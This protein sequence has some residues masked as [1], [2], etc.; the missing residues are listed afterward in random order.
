[1]AQPAL[2]N[3]VI[4]AAKAG[5]IAYNRP[6]MSVL[7]RDRRPSSFLRDISLSRWALPLSCVCLLL[8]PGC[9]DPDLD[10]DGV[11][12]AED[13]APASPDIRPGQWEACD[14][15]DNNCD[16]QIDELYDLDLDGFYADDPGC[17]AL[18]LGI[19]CNDLDPTVYPGALEALDG[20]DN[21]C[22]GQIDERPDVDDDGYD[23][24]IDCD[25][26]NPFIHPGALEV[27]DGIDNDC[28]GAIDPMWDQDGDG[29]SQCAEIPDCDDDDPLNGPH[30]PEIC[31]GQDNDCDNRSDEGFDQDGDGFTTCRG[32]CNDNDP[33]V[34]PSVA[35]IC[36]DGVDNDCDPS[37][38]EVED[39]DGDGITYCAG[40]CND[41]NPL[42]YPGALEYCDGIDN[43]C[44]GIADEP[45]GCWD[46]TSAGTQD[47]LVCTTQVSFSAARDAC[48]VFGGRLVIIGDA[49][50]NNFVSNLAWSVQPGAYWLGLTDQVQEDVW[51][52]VDGSLLGYE[53]WGPGEPNNAGGEDCAHTNFNG[54]IGVW[55][56][57]PCNADEPFVCEF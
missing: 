44:N 42:I 28:D 27:C 23:A 13:C 19:D 43:D 46:C 26:G 14:G 36:G 35:E 22:D 48:S 2:A 34:A 29:A 9:S 41:S 4:G 10:G 12:D 7:L 56:D 50:E 1:M 25:D 37:T 49:V 55:N 33:T 11:P 32:D 57:L 54:N 17:R 45:I 52:W 24:S 18:G 15:I 6:V 31:D 38:S 53:A 39:L 20:V 47:Y 16:G 21:N 8:A 3:R 51:R 30:L 5:D 40:D